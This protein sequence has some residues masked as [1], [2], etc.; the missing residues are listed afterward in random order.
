MVDCVI[1]YKFAL[2]KHTYCMWIFFIYEIVCHFVKLLCY[3]TI[4]K[5]I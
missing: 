2:E 4:G 3:N 5:K 1:V